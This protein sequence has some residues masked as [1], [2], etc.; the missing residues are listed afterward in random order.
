V[1]FEWPLS[2]VFSLRVHL[3]ALFDLRRPTLEIGGAPA[4]AAPIVAGTV[5]AGVAA[6]I[7]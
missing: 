5:G 2:R 7:Q 6:Y 4:W 3:D 1:G